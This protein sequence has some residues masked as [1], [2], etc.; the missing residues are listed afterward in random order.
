MTNAI[1]V[2][3]LLIGVRPSSDSRLPLKVTPPSPVNLSLWNCGEHLV[4]RSGQFSPPDDPYKKNTDCMWAI[5]V[6]EGHGI[7]FRIDGIDLE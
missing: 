2:Y 3:R 5:E 6:T 7:Q 1:Y 4:G